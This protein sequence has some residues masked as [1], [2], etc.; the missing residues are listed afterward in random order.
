MVALPDCHPT[1]TAAAQGSA[2]VP[3]EAACVVAERQL[4]EDALHFVAERGWAISGEEFFPSLV[5]HLAQWLGVDYALVARL[6]PDEQ[7]ETVAFSALGGML[8]PLRYPLRDTPCEHVIGKTLCCYPRHVQQLFPRSQML[9]QMQIESYAGMPLW[10]SQGQPLGAI[11]VMDGKPMEHVPRVE[12]L[13]RLVA[14]R[15]SAELERQRAEATLRESEERYRLLVET[16]PQ[17]AW[18]AGPNGDVLDCNRSWYEYTGHSP[19]DVQTHGWLRAVHPDDLDQVI[20]RLTQAVRS[21]APYEVECRLRRAADG[22]YR[23]YLARALPMRDSQGEVVAWFGCAT[24]IDDLKRVEQTLREREERYQEF[25]RQG[26]EGISRWETDQPFL[27][28]LPEDEQIDLFF[29]YAYLAECNAAYAR[30][31]GRS[32]PED[33]VG[34]KLGD[35]ISR[36]DPRNL[37]SFRAF[38]RGGH[39]TEDAESYEVDAQG[40]THCFSNTTAGIVEDGRLVRV[41]SIQRDVTARKRAEEQL[42]RQTRTLHAVMAAV[43]DQV[44][45][46]DR[47]K[48]YVYANPAALA[49]LGVTWETL[50]NK[51]WREAGLPAAAI[52]PLAAAVDQVLATGE[53]HR[54]EVSLPSADGGHEY[55]YIINPVW[56]EGGQI[57]AVVISA[58]HTT[59]RRRADAAWRERAE[60]LS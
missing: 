31:Y 28:T 33:M 10:D 2:P 8:S 21:G 48:R 17:L 30:M 43:A 24:D 49:A 11:A 40:N 53:A 6:L 19:K 13:L 4:L 3:E 51:T 22:R 15:V 14:T 54:G 18:R 12:S 7:A 58:R 20:D 45:M 25:L 5:Q 35:L 38:L 47:G 46:W 39:R 44:Y 41:W 9:V 16:I 57:E 52:E 36:T 32:R 1:T 55:E 60:N 59:D 27:V 56:D 34:L 37:A 50:A 42:A 26:A 23:W 29:R